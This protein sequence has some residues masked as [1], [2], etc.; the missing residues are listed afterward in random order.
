MAE[1]FNALLQN[2][3]WSLVPPPPQANMVGSTWKFRIKYLA[4]GSIDRYKA[5]LVAQGFRQQPAS[6]CMPHE[7]STCRL[8][9]EFYVIFGDQ[10]PMGLLYAGPLTY[11]SQPA[12][13]PIGLVAWTPDDRQQAM[14]Y[15]LDQISSP[16]APRNSLRCLKARERLNIEP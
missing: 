3:T 5:R 13:M 4:D 12:R 7:R 11:R 8:R 10:S 14:Q 9:R 15:L 2:G 1:E 16:S 6:L